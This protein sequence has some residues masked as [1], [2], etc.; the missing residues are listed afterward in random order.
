M[1]VGKGFS[2]SAEPCAAKE[3]PPSL[4]FRLQ[5]RFHVVGWVIIFSTEICRVFDQ[6]AFIVVTAV[7]AIDFDLFDGVGIGYQFSDGQ[8]C[9]GRRRRGSSGGDGA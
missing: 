5:F 7:N 3:T 6:A 8:R 1:Q 2:L 4:E 9:D